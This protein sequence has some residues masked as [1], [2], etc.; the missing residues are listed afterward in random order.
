MNR[1]LG[2]MMLLFVIGAEVVGFAQWIGPAG[3][4]DSSAVVESSTAR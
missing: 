3:D 2:V 4:A 1:L